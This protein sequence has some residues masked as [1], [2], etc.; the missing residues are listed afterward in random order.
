MRQ[1]T[2]VRA[3]I[4]S[5]CAGAAVLIALILVGGNLDQTTAKLIGTA[6]ALASFSLT[7]VAGSNLGLRRP[8]LNAF[9]YLTV[10]ISALAFVAM[11]ITLWFDSLWGSGDGWR[12]AVYML[13]LAFACGHT[14]VLLASG[15]SEDPE[16]VRVVRGGTIATLWILVA[17]VFGEISS[18]GPDGAQEPIAIIAV[19]YLLGVILLPL[20]RRSGGGGT[21]GAPAAA[22][23]DGARSGGEALGLDHLVIGVSDWERSAA[24]YRDVLGA[25]VSELSEARMAYRLGAQQINVHGPGTDAQPL[26]HDPVRPG[27]SDLCFAWSG[28]PGQAREHLRRLGVEP[29]LG[30]VPREGARGSGQS[31]YCRDPDGSLIELIAY[32]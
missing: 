29:I 13:I 11:V 12:P 28:T 6:V 20:L 4:G 16:P 5:L 1:S 14:S 25:E 27:N 32:G 24:F 7:A 10:A 8:S 23:S 22:T 3:A 19:L 21:R 15:R 2:I 9:G 31:V 17:L 26:A 18:P 30:P